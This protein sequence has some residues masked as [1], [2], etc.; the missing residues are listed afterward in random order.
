MSIVSRC[1]MGAMASK[2]ASD[3]SPVSVRMA[4]ARAGEVRGPV[5]MMTRSQSSGGSPAISPSAT[6]TSGWRFSVSVTSA[7]KASRST[8]SAPPAGTW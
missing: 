6:V 2:K 5:A 7:E 1:T 3:S 8:A 4:C